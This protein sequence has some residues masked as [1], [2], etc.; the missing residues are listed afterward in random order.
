MT[1]KKVEPKVPFG[2]K[3]ISEFFGTS[4]NFKKVEKKSKV[5]KQKNHTIERQS[6]IISITDIDDDDGFGD[7]HDVSIDADTSAEMM[8]FRDPKL[9]SVLQNK[10]NN[11]NKSSSQLTRTNSILSEKNSNDLNHETTSISLKRSSTDLLDSFEGGKAKKVLKQSSVVSNIEIPT[12]NQNLSSEQLEVITKVVDQKL[13]VFYTGSA[14]TGKS[15]VLRELVR[16]LKAIYRDNIGVTAPTG[17]AACNINGQ[18]IYRYLEIGL[19]LQNPTDLA[20]IIQRNPAKLRKWTM[21]KVLIIDEISMVDGYFFDKL[22]ET[23]RRVRGNAAPFGGIQIVCCGDFYQLPP[24]S[25]NGKVTKFCFQ[26]KSWNLVIQENI[27]LKQIFR[28]KGDNELIEMLN[29]LRNGSIKNQPSMIEKFHK[30]NKSVKYDDG[31]EP[32]QLYPTRREVLEA[33]GCRLKQLNSKIYEYSAIDSHPEE[34]YKSHYSQLLCEDKLIL[35]EGAQVMNIKNMDD[36]LANGSLGTVLCFLTRNLFFKI[37]ELYGS[38]EDLDPQMLKEVKLISTRIGVVQEWNEE[39][40]QIIEN[41]PDDRKSKFESLVQYTAQETKADI[42]PVVLYKLN[43]SDQARLVDREEFVIELGKEKTATGNPTRIQLPIILAW[44]MSIHKA[45]GQTI[46]RL[47][48]DLNKIFE[49]GHAY[50]AISRAV[51]KENLQVNN[52]RP[53]KIRISQVVHDFYKSLEARSEKS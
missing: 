27:V 39:E 46:P 28:Q 19:G 20:R 52:F 31:I 26:A 8:N 9:N 42:L 35:K 30:L 50:V 18:T 32:T 14:G 48:V 34:S 45:Q 40:K 49:N 7:G 1:R 43:G 12:Y 4:S 37:L 47:K 23:A 51:S 13:N 10:F 44:A 21:M 29:A 33:N 53:D 15:V 16:K 36:Q 6:S 22:E 2:Q 17:M 11:P 41:M 24:V 25:S 3:V 38:I 5:S